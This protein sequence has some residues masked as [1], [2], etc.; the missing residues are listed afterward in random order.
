MTTF[1]DLLVLNHPCIPG[2]NSTRSWCAIPECTTEFGLLISCWEFLY[3]HSSGMLACNFLF[4]DVSGF[5]IRVMESISWNEYGRIL[6]FS[7][8]WN[9]L[10]TT[11]H[12]KS[13]NYSKWKNSLQNTTYNN[14]HKKKCKISTT[15]WPN[16]EIKS[17]TINLHEGESPGANGFPRNTSKA[18]ENK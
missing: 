6:S 9:I 2:I 16:K 18:S 1:I 10:W 8:F 3:L 5:R 7:A 17:E 11:F 13:V 15:L 14:Y 4:C 12:H